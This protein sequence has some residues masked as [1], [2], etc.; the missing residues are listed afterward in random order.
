[1]LVVAIAVT[2]GL[3][4]KPTPTIPPTT[5]P[6]TQPIKPPKPPATPAAQQD[7]SKLERQ[8]RNP[9][10]DRLELRPEVIVAKHVIGLINEKTSDKKIMNEAN[11]L[12]NEDSLSKIRKTLN[13]R[14]GSGDEFFQAEQFNE[15][16]K[17]IDKSLQKATVQDLN[18]WL[19][20]PDSTTKNAPWPLCIISGC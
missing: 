7:A 9:D 10:V 20:G 18:D 4:Q 6:T 5:Q 16:L 12:L 19:L 17:N 8:G 3:A 2:A 11:K 15:Q 1:M 14:L 13:K